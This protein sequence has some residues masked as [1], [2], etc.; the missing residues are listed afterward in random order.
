MASVKMRQGQSL[1]MNYWLRARVG[2]QGKSPNPPPIVPFIDLDLDT[3]GVA[4]LA[5]S[6]SAGVWS[7]AF[8]NKDKEYPGWLGP[9]P[10]SALGVVEGEEATKMQFEERMK[11]AEQSHIA[12]TGSSAPNPQNSAF[13]FVPQKTLSVEKNVDGAE[14][15]PQ[16][17]WSWLKGGK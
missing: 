17:W 8:P 2:T 14:K 16:G 7:R 15:N 1:Q 5:I 6:W 11:K 12:E 10:N 3:T 4:I 9:L 13:A